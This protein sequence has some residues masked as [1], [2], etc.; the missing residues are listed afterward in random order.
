VVGGFSFYQRAEVKDALAYLK[1]VISPQDSVSLLR[2]INTPARGIGKSTIEQIEQ[3]ALG[4]RVERMVGDR[5]HAGGKSFPGRAESALRIFKS[6][7]EELGAQ[8]PPKEK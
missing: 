7:M 3:Y 6:M 4:A 1:A 5:P 2:I 8:P